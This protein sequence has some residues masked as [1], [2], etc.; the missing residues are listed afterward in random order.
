MR[1]STDNQH[2][3]I[4]YSFLG[5]LYLSPHLIL[6]TIL[7]IVILSQIHRQTDAHSVNNLSNV[8]QVTRN[9]V[10]LD[11]T[12]SHWFLEMCFEIHDNGKTVLSNTGSTKTT[13]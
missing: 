4:I 12:T 10:L 11:Y 1:S 7:L 6:D 13:L 8:T 3:L 5:A 9:L 2:F